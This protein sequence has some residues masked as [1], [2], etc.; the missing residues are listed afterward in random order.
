M[1]AEKKITVKAANVVVKGYTYGIGD[2]RI[3]FTSDTEAKMF[4]VGAED[5]EKIPAK[6]TVDGTKIVVTAKKDDVYV[7]D[8]VTLTKDVVITGTA[9]KDVSKI[10][11]TEVDADAALNEF[12][13][14]VNDVLTNLVH[15]FVGLSASDFGLASLTKSGTTNLT[16]DISMKNAKLHS[17]KGELRV[18]AGEDS[19]S[20]AVNY[21]GG[22]KA[23]IS[24]SVTV[25]SISRYISVPVIEGAT[26]TKITVSYKSVTSDK[27]STT[28]QIGLFD[29]AGAPIGT[30][31]TID[32]TKASGSD[33]TATLTAN[34]S[35]GTTTAYLVFSR[36]GAGGGGI[37]VYSIKVE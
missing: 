35:T 15:N 18:R 30:V 12:C 8:G 13:P 4:L 7:P 33:E 9:E 31:A 29:Q 6:Y 24:G 21:N 22:E 16:G 1:K 20:T 2:L 3:E 19:L 32:T 28:C 36:N 25:S 37:D 26:K 14:K 10:T 17:P 11:I 5:N 27:G 34:V 23:D